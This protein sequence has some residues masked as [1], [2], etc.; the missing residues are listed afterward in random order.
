MSLNTVDSIENFVSDVNSGRWDQVLPIVSR[1]KLPQ[2]KL[3]NLYEQVSAIELQL[4]QAGLSVCRHM[5][6][7]LCQVVLEM[8]ELRE[9][10]TARA[11]LRQTQVFNRM[12]QEEPDRFLKLEH[13][14]GRTY[15]DI[16]C[17]GGSGLT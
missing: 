12:K 10:D 14:C 16:R 1:L 17:V 13:L 8:V 7:C 3:E 4:C 5:H 9:V 2:G 15:F 11:M 6:A